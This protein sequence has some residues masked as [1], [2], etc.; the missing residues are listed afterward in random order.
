MMNSQPA[1]VAMEDPMEL[2]SAVTTYNYRCAKLG[3]D[4]GMKPGCNGSWVP[5]PNHP[6]FYPATEYIYTNYN[7]SSFNAYKIYSPGVERE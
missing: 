4:V 1:Q 3:G 6:R 7:T 2:C 5:I